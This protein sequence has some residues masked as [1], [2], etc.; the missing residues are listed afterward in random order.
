MINSLYQ[1]QRWNDPSGFKI[2]AE[3]EIFI[4]FSTLSFQNLADHAE[5]HE[6]A[7]A[8][9]QHWIAITV[10]TRDLNTNY[11][12]FKVKLYM[13]FLKYWGNESFRRHWTF[14][15]NEERNRRQD[16]KKVHLKNIWRCHAHSSE[17]DLRR[18]G[19]LLSVTIA[20][21]HR[22]QIPQI[23]RSYFKG[24]YSLSGL[25]LRLLWVLVRDTM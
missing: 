23:H 10:L 7:T 6:M 4:L 18:P 14:L 20:W 17:K 13:N 21:S 2:C 19:T 3:N 24:V 16:K 8:C 1:N 9:I 15:Q 12:H 11:Q 5:T 22:R 25:L